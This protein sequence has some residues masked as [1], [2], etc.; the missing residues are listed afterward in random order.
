MFYCWNGEFY[1][2]SCMYPNPKCFY[3]CLG[4][5]LWFLLTRNCSVTRS[6]GLEPGV[7]VIVHITVCLFPTLYC[8]S[9]ST[10]S[11]HIPTSPSSLPTSFLSLPPSFTTYLLLLSLSP[12]LPPLLLSLFSLSLS[13]SPPLLSPL[14]MTQ[15]MCW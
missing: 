11:L 6:R 2:Q 15:A 9:P 1:W 4:T 13:P 7:V 10:F 8:L 3:L 12:L 14:F 5:G